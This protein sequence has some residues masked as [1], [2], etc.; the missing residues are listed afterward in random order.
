MKS[1]HGRYEV[2]NEHEHATLLAH[3]DALM[4]KNE[5]NVTV[6][7][8]DEIRQMG[9]VA[10]KCG[11]GIYPITAPKTLEGIMEL[12]MYEMRLEQLGHTKTQ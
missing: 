9:L 5:E 4:R 7:E 10:Q 6:E 1:E 11:L 8:S 3:V 12:R 2:T